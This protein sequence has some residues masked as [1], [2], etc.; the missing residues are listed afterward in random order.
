MFQQQEYPN[1]ITFWRKIFL[2]YLYKKI[3]FKQVQYNNLRFAKLV[4]FL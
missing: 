2:L 1:H 3:N 4:N